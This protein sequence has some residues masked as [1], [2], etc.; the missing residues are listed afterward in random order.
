MPKLPKSLDQLRT[1]AADARLRAIQS[2][3]A[4]AFTL[5]RTVD[6]AI[7][8]GEIEEASKVIQKLLY[9]AEAIRHHVDEPHHVPPASVPDLRQQL[10]KPDTRIRDLEKQLTST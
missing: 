10:A 7:R 6:S 3:L 1:E 5:C 2:Q 9:N 4:A 8:L